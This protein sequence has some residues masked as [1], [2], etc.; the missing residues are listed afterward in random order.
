MPSGV[1]IWNTPKIPSRD[2]SILQQKGFWNKFA[3][4]LVELTHILKEAKEDS[5][6]R[7][8]S[9]HPQDDPDRPEPG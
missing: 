4:Q 1:E 2:K 9:T 5:P 7:T 3:E 8:S 6:E